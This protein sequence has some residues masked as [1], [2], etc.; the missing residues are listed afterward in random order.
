MTKR[1]KCSC[2]V[3]EHCYCGDCGRLMLHFDS[4]LV[5]AMS[6]VEALHLITGCQPRQKGCVLCELS[7]YAPNHQ[8]TMRSVK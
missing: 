6:A 1:S 8:R 2:R 5:K 3:G 4:S 7:R